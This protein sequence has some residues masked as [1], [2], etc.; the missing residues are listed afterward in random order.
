MYAGKIAHPASWE[1]DSGFSGSDP[2]QVGCLECVLFSIS[3]RDDNHID[4]R[5]LHGNVNHQSEYDPANQH[6]HDKMQC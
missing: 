4:F 3:K 5:I 1:D 2:S 6:S